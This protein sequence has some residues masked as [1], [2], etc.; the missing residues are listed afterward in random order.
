MR[1]IIIG[2]FVLALSIIIIISGHFPHFTNFNARTS[3]LNSYRPKYMSYSKQPTNYILSPEVM[4][5]HV[6]LASKRAGLSMPPEYFE[7]NMDLCNV[8]NAE[9]TSWNPNIFNK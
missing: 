7:N 8:N 2:A 4:A 6:E 5:L 9:F 3:E 1:I